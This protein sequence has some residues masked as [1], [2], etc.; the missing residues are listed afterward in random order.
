MALQKAPQVSFGAASGTQRTVVSVDT[1]RALREANLMVE[2]SHRVRP[3]WFDGKFLAA[4]DLTREQAY[5][6]AR[7]AGFARALGPGVV[8]GLEVSQGSVATELQVSPG[9][10]YTTAGELVALTG[11]VR[12]SLAQLFQL[13][14]LAQQL[15][16]GKKKLLIPPLRNRTGIFVLGLRALEFSANPVSSYPTGLDA[17]RT[18]EPGDIVEASALTLHYVADAPAERI[19]ALRGELA[20]EVFVQQAGPA[21]PAETLALALVALTGD[22]VRWIDVHLARR[23]AGQSHA[24]V[25][26]FGFAPRLLREAHLAQYQDHLDDVMKRPLGARPS[27]AQFFSSLPAAGPLPAAAVNTADFSQSWLPA[28]IDAELTLVP[29]DEIA[30]LVEESLTLPPIDLQLGAD[31]Q[32][33]TF[34]SILVPVPREALAAQA[35]ALQQRLTRLLTVP[36]TRLPIKRSPA[37]SLRLLENTRL[38]KTGLFPPAPPTDP[39]DTAWASLVN[40]QTTL[41]YARRRNVS[42]RPEVEGVAV[43]VINEGPNPD[44]IIRERFKALGETERVEKLLAR[45]DSLARAEA[46]K[47]LSATK[48]SEPLMAHVAL[49]QLEARKTLDE[50]AVAEVATALNKPGVSDGLAKLAVQRPD[51]LEDK[52]ALHKL[53]GSEHLLDMGRTLSRSSGQEAQ[54]LSADI[55]VPARGKANLDKVL[56]ARFTPAKPR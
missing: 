48:F 27:A 12:V 28:G 43:A 51:L 5:F 24:D 8:E 49:A 46:V 29:Q 54:R 15:N 42:L 37:E 2:E 19:E 53:A 11:P 4:R 36:A 10:G 26:G 41:W 39:V 17:E 30:M 45:S 35:R 40:A 38:V 31:S 18:V 50:S 6:L 16:A 52:E 33:S 14:T 3:R 25:L 23:T 56:A 34:V 44:N 21:L 9:F 55:K 7:Q 20:R 47:L 22:T 32:T 13:Q 1:A